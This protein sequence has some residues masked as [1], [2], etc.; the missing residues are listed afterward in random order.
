MVDSAKV[1][2]KNDAQL[3]LPTIKG[4]ATSSSFISSLKVVNAFKAVYGSEQGD[5]L[6]KTKMKQI[7]AAYNKLT[8]NPLSVYVE[9]GY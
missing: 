2:G 7:L 1:N 5:K 3:T 4:V 9:K 6:I 8:I